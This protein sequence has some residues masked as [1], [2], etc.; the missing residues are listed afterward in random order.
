[1]PKLSILRLRAVRDFGLQPRLHPL[2]TAWLLIR[3]RTLG[4][5]KGLGLFKQFSRHAKRYAASVNKLSA[6]APAHQQFTQRTLGTD[7]ETTDDNYLF[8]VAFAFE[9]VC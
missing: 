3:K 9:P 2:T 6:L 8:D 5:L 1:M 7:C 4:L